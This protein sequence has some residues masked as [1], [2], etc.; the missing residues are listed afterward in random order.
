LR[1]N[2]KGEQAMRKMN[3]ITLAE[4]LAQI[5]DPQDARGKRFEVSSPKVLD[6]VTDGTA[7]PAR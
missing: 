2:K 6:Q 4:T 7:T 3:Y 1:T 5:E